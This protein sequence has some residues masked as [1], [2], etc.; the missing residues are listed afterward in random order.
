MTPRAAGKKRPEPRHKAVIYWQKAQ[1]FAHAAQT[2]ASQGDWDPAVANAVNATINLTDALCVHYMGARSAS[3]SH[4]DVLG[5]LAT[6][7]DMPLALRTALTRHLEALLDVK[8]VAQYEGRL[9]SSQDAQRALQHMDRAFHAAAE[10]AKGEG[11]P[12]RPKES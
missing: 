10:I 2:N 6:V 8:G 3:D 4:F 7:P 9:L 1:R 12:I 11:W 5:L